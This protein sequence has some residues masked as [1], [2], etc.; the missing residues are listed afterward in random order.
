MHLVKYYN[1]KQSVII[2]SFT[3]LNAKKLKNGSSYD[4]KRTF[5]SAVI[6]TS[7]DLYFGSS[8]VTPIIREI[9]TNT[10]EKVYDIY[11]K[12]DKNE[13]LKVFKFTLFSF[14][15][16]IYIVRGGICL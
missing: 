14:F 9:M 5:G 11:N 10:Y 1:R 6:G 15:L 8:S 12:K 13:L 4:A 7:S 2:L 16:Y 3:A